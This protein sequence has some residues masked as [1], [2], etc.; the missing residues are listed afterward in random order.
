MKEIWKEVRENFS[1][2]DKR[3]DQ[4]HQLITRAHLLKKSAISGMKR[5]VNYKRRL[6]PDDSTSTFLMVKKLQEED[7][8]IILVYKP[9][10][11]K[12]LIGSKMYDNIDLKNNIFAFGFQTKEQLKIFGKQAYKI[13]Y[14][15]ATH[16]TNQYKFPLINL[17]VPDEFNKGYPVAHLIC[18]REDELVLIPFFQVI[19][20]RYSNPNLEINAVMTDDNSGWNAF[21]RVFGDCT[22]LLCKWHVKRAWGNKIPLCGSKQLQEEVYRTL[23]V[24]LEETSIETFE[25]MLVGL[26]RKYLDIC[27]KFVNYFK[28]TYVSR[29]VK[30]AMCY[31]QFE[32]TNTDTNLFVESFHNKL[33][34][35]YLER[36]PNKRIDDLTNVLL[37]IE[38]DH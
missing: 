6:H 32:H 8:N 27:P 30:S 7:L 35:F 15:D 5:N 16:E 13:V 36:M 4:Q 14:I 3:D 17:V 22:Q 19:Q 10:G 23:E 24:I 37:E 28:N 25:K 38:T 9:Q 11:Q 29:P 26:L 18:N 12:T 31:R 33:K 1:D 34:T 21:S 20:E 2:R